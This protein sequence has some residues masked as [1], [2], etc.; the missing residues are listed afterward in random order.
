LEEIMIPYWFLNIKTNM[1]AFHIIIFIVLLTFGC[2][3]QSAVDKMINKGLSSGERY[4][5][6]F[7]GLSLGMPKQAF[8]DHCT[9]L[10]KKKMITNT[11]RNYSVLYLID[12]LDHQARMSFYP[13]FWNKKI[14]YMSVLFEYT[15]WAPWN[16]EMF[17]D[18]LSLD[19]I[20]L[21]KDWYDM[22]FITMEEE[23]KSKYVSVKGNKLIEVMPKDDR[24]V[25]VH[26]TDLQA[27]NEIEENGKENEIR[28]KF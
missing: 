8:L 19:I 23:N 11:G 27:K 5:S 20:E 18:S 16:R 28:Y 15:A 14:A 12:E 4:D 1:Q 26:I 22:K 17:S 2:T 21:Y 25:I 10:N 13:T 9:Q 6:L 7:L 3:S 24:D